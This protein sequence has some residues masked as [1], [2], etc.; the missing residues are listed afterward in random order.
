MFADCYAGLHLF[1]AGGAIGEAGGHVGPFAFDAERDRGAA[2]Q[3]RNF[4]ERVAARP[5]RVAFGNELMIVGVAPRCGGGEFFRRWTLA[6]ADENAMLAQILKQIFGD[7]ARG[8]RE[9]EAAIIAE[10]ERVAA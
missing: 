3:I 1:A 8:N 10:I 6:G 2:M 9:W 5:H 4:A 7:V